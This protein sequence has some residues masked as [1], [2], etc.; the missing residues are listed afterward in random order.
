MVVDEFA[1]EAA[2][3]HDAVELRQVQLAGVPL[4]FLSPMFATRTHPEWKP[5]GHMRAAALLRLAKVPVIA[6]GGMTERRFMRIQ[7]LGFCGWAAM[8]AWIRT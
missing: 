2:R 7:R 3:V 4:L 8:D 5:F 1:G 6:L